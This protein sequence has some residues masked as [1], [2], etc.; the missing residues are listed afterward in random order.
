MIRYALRAAFTGAFAVL[1]L[2]C[3]KNSIQAEVQPAPAPNPDE[4]LE[5][6]ELEASDTAVFLEYKERSQE[7]RLMSVDNGRTYTVSINN[8]T[9]FEDSFLKWAWWLMP[10]FPYI[11]RS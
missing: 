3:G 10:T 9:T 11:Q 7:V 2:S 4:K 8:L 1:L 6:T 5:I